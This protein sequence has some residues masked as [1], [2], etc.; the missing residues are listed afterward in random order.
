L[1]KLSDAMM[2]RAHK[3]SRLDDCRPAKARLT[4]LKAVADDYRRRYASRA[5]D[6]L[7]HFRQQRTLIAAIRLASRAEN[8]T[9][10]RFAHQRRI[11]ARVLRQVE[12]ALIA[13]ARS[14]REA[15]SF[16]EL[17]TT[18][19]ALIGDIHGVGDL[20]TYDTTLRIG[21]WL[22]SKPERVYLHAGTRA[23]ARALGLASGEASLRRSDIPSA[24]RVLPSDQIEDVLCI[25]KDQFSYIRISKS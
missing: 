6:E 19:A 8:R 17:Y 18:I 4:N 13:S 25:Y 2:D 11:P 10:K 20:L 23:G 5:D 22:R 15:R 9:G 7:A 3:L 12:T 14:I 24:L 21:A 16:H 1:L